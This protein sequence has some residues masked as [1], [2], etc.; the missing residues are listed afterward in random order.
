MAYTSRLAHLCRRP[1]PTLTPGLLG[2]HTST[3]T[4]PCSSMSLHCTSSSMPPHCFT[5][6]SMSARCTNNSSSMS[7]HCFTS[8]MSFHC[9]SRNTC[10]LCTSSNSSYNSSS[11]SSNCNNSNCNNS[12]CNNSNCNNSNCNSSSCNNS[13]SPPGLDSP[14]Y[15]TVAPQHI[16][17]YPPF[18]PSQQYRP[19]PNPRVGAAGLPPSMAGPD[20][21]PILRTTHPRSPLGGPGSL[22]CPTSLSEQ[23]AAPPVWTPRVA[24]PT[25]AMPPI[26]DP[27]RVDHH[28]QS[29]EHE[30]KTRSLPTRC[31]HKPPRPGGTG[32]EKGA[33]GGRVCE[34]DGFYYSPTVEEDGVEE[35]LFGSSEDLSSGSSILEKLMV[36]AY[37]S[38]PEEETSEAVETIQNLVMC[39]TCEVQATTSPATCEVQATTSPAT[40]EVQATTSPATCEVQATTSPATCEV[41]ATTSPL[42]ISDEE[43]QCCSR[44]RG[45][46]A[47]LLVAQTQPARGSNPTC[48]WLKQPARNSTPT[49]SW[50]ILNLLV[51]ET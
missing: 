17:R 3:T 18:Q 24:H 20:D 38:D 28:P 30:L 4:Y 31:S 22:S 47:N 13:N 2:L 19:P 49:C 26:P 29:E 33:G 10:T 35:N 32:G 37:Y 48:S 6:S 36:W 14:V 21:L 15:Y 34:E 46:R 39:S 1:H 7:P 16:S 5:S 27:P 12:N 45:G 23:G 43:A 11:N 40:C 51:S 9:I 8:S 42:V 25:P 44:V 50:P 41:Q